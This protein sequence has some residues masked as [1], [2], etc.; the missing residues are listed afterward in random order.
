M[1]PYAAV[2][3]E[4][5]RARQQRHGDQVDSG[6]SKKGACSHGI[7]LLYQPLQDWRQT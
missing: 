7:L 4:S 6:I 1:T 5:R 3:F 2:V